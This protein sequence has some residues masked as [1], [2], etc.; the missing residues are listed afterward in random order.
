MTTSSPSDAA[1]AGSTLRITRARGL[2]YRVPAEV[3]TPGAKYNFVVELTGTTPQD[4]SFVGLGESQ[5]RG[6]RTGDEPI[7]SWA[8]LS[9][10]VRQLEGFRL[11][12]GDT[13]SA[14]H[15]I[16]EQMRYFEGLADVFAFE[17]DRTHPFRGTMI[18]VEMALLDLWARAEK[19]TLTQLLGQKREK[20]SGI[21]RAQHVGE[22]YDRVAAIQE[23]RNGEYRRVR[24]SA[25]TKNFDVDDYMAWVTSINEKRRDG[26]AADKPLWIDF[27]GKFT[28]EEASEFVEQVTAAALAGELAKKIVIEQP[29]PMRYGHH[30][31]VLQQAIDRQVPADSDIDIR[32]MGDESVWDGASLENLDEVGGL[33]AI[34]IRPA[35]V[36][37]LLGTLDVAEQALERDP[38]TAIF[39]TRMIGASRITSGALRHLA[40]SMPAISDANIV[41]VVEHALPVTELE[42]EGVIDDAPSLYADEDEAESIIDVVGDSEDTDEDESDEEAA[43]GDD[44]ETP[45]HQSTSS[46]R[47][48][49]VPRYRQFSH[50]EAP[51]IG[52]RFTVNRLVG[53]IENIVSH[54]P[55]P[56]VQYEGMAPTVYNDVDNL[57]P[58]G[59]NG[60]KGHLLEREALALGLNTVRYSKGAFIASDGENEPLTFKWSRNPLSSAVA[61]ALC[62]HKEGTRLQLQRSG[63]PVPQ[64]RT[65]TN[66]DFGTAKAFAER[67]GYPV[68]V[69]PAM[70]VRGIGVVANIQDDQQLDAAFE[71]MSGSK[72]GNQDFIV[73]KHVNGRDYRIVVV[74][75][76]VVAAILRE[77]ASVFGDGAR[78]VAELMIDK[79][80]ARRR[81]PHLWARPAK[82][83]AAARYEL[84]RAGMTLES[85]PAPGER[86]QLAN[87]CSL[88][89][90]GDSIDVL[91][92][93]HPSIIEACVKTVNSIPGLE[94]CGVDFLLEDHT[95]PLD[96][97][98]AG[99]CE[100]NAHAAI[101]NCEYPMY[102]TPRP[103]AKTLMRATVDHYGVN[104]RPQPA[105][106]VTLKLRIRGKVT[107][108]GFRKWLRRRA[109][110]SGVTGWVR[111]VNSRTLEA[112]ISGP[113]APTT[114]LAASTI[115]GPKRAL[116]TTYTAEHIDAPKTNTF[117]ILETAESDG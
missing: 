6:W 27:N 44:E 101:G 7:S 62:T 14:K 89:Q 22:I 2:S 85:V 35:Q 86:V 102:G 49:R 24:L 80:V 91:D 34:N 76:Q 104:A 71:L 67:I 57:H 53:E 73:E 93:M 33:R 51:G 81:N 32:I 107:G 94:Y 61:L 38:D 56:V 58:L 113:T 64:G 4:E 1:G 63:I 109:R 90:G 87:T 48:P 105:R 69:K 30:L 54:P 11:P 21:L 59:A 13:T 82:Y 77:P 72:L 20:T 96:E 117:Q 29:V 97:Q 36:G 50:A 45:S 116:P 112:V 98:D 40:L 46:K 42:G 17:P 31:V 108:V 65:F 23:L 37:G 60:S 111:N 114:A 95:K 84:G 39:L 3:T 110:Q 99:I 100:L 75:D 26:D 78:T 16:R 41:A 68:V 43:E 92:E 5:P 79:N 47:R 15:V 52:V 25:K 18:G 19:M 8:F 115:L 88:S 12:L 83:D 9:E 106:H 55:T 70:G 103:V 28:R 74:G 66:G 10:M